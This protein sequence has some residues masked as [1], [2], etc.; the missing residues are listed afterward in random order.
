MFS[1]PFQGRFSLAVHGSKSVCTNST[2]EF[3]EMTVG[4]LQILK[5]EM[6]SKTNSSEYSLCTSQTCPEH[7]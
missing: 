3:P 6:F 4:D 2:R 7:I 5:E 1:K